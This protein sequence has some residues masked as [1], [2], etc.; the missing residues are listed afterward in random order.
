MSRPWTA[1]GVA[2]HNLPDALLRTQPDTDGVVRPVE[3]EFSALY[4]GTFAPI[5]AFVRGQ[6]SS[7]DSANDL[8]SQIF[9]KSYRHWSRAPRGEAATFWLFRIARNTLIDYWRVEGRRESVNVPLDELADVGDG[10]A[11]PEA[12]CS[13]KERAARLLK[14]VGSLGKDDRVLLSLKFTGQRTNREIAA[15]LGISDPAVSMRLLRA[16]RRLRERLSD[17]DIP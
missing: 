14:A 7:A 9:L 8:V 16:L 6:V 17:V 3:A 10:R 1:A 5:Y 4:E 12:M 13:A 15:I 2:A 11:N